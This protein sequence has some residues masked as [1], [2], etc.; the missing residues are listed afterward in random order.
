MCL[1]RDI[2][3]SCW[4]P[5]VFF[6]FCCLSV[7]CCTYRLQRRAASVRV[8][9]C[10]GATRPGAGGSDWGCWDCAAASRTGCP[11]GLAGRDDTKPHT[12]TH[13]DPNT[14]TY[15]TRRRSDAPGQRGEGEEM[16]ETGR[17][18]ETKTKRGKRRKTGRSQSQDTRSSPPEGQK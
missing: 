14:H 10:G 1:G 15:I 9:G 13:E 12:H 7:M 5:S 17:Q 11:N 8:A 3:P 4:C 18:D 6:F 16:D 2:G